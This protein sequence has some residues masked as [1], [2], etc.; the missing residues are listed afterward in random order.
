MN[1]SDSFPEACQSSSWIDSAKLS[2]SGLMKNTAIQVFV[3]HDCGRLSLFDLCMA[4]Y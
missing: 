2:V 4:E 3:Y 1:E